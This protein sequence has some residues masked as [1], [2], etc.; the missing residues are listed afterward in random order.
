MTEITKNLILYSR[1]KL[2]SRILAFIP[3]ENENKV[4]C[5]LSCAFAYNPYKSQESVNYRIGFESDFEIDLTDEP[6]SAT[7]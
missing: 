7:L 2:V 6:N 4:L 1:K 3:F 5:Y